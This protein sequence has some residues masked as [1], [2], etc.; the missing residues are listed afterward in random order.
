MGARRGVLGAQLVWLVLGCMPTE[1]RFADL[2]LD[3]PGA[4]PEQAETVRVCVEGAGERDFGARLSGL[5]TLTGLPVGQ[6]ARVQVDVFDEEGT[7][8]ISGSGTVLDYAVGLRLECAA[9]A[10]CEPCEDDGDPVSEEDSA[11]LL[12]VRFLG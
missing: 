2:Q 9:G 4:M 5:F 7:L 12:A 1:H 10:V 3:L 8:L 6:E 11:W